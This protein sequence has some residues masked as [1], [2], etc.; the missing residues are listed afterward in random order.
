MGSLAI[1]KKSFAFIIILLKLTVV[2]GLAWLVYKRFW[3]EEQGQIM[4]SSFPQKIKEGQLSWL[5]MVL[6]LAPIN[7]LLEIKKWLHLTAPFQRLSNKEAA[8]ALLSG[9]CLGILSPSRI[10][11]YGGRLLHIY[12]E[13]RPKALYAHFIGS[14]AQNIPILL[15]GGVAVA[16]FFG[17][18]YIQN[19]TLSIGLGALLVCFAIALMLL[20]PNHRAL[21]DKLSEWKWTQRFTSNLATYQINKEVMKQVGLLALMRFVI[22]LTQYLLLLYFFKIE[23]D[24]S[25]A[26]V[27]ICVIY[28]VQTGLPL[29]PAMSV[30][31]RAELA[32]LVWTFYSAD[33][34]AILSVP[35]LLWTINL[36]I[37]AIFGAWVILNANLTKEKEFTT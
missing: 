11:E 20:Y 22:Y 33:Q 10:A 15:C 13:N 32:L 9:I 6:L 21:L 18:Y 8:Q 37:P 30:I 25:Y 17:K 28:L 23:V 34:V 14:V 2:W 7:W 16:V 31:A 27:G 26:L 29:P 35:I 12:P 1:H 5:A 4:W 3:L 19:Y 24:F 36:L